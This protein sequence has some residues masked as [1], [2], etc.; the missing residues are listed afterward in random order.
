MSDRQ[1]AASPFLAPSAFQPR[2]QLS[3]NVRFKKNILPR[4]KG[5]EW[6]IDAMN[7]KDPKL[8]VLQF[9][10]CINKQDIE[11]LSNLM[12]DNHVFIDSSDDVHRGKESMIKGWIEFFN[13]YPDYRNH[14]P[15]IESRENLVLIIGYS[16]CSH[17]T[18]DGPAIW[19]AN[20]ENDLVAE[21]RVYL[22]TQENRAKLKL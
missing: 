22:D 1:K 12:A 6:S 3:S 4:A 15:K 21:W 10:E 2:R 14:F 20:I 17:N 9:N 11:G 8:T 19:T 16:T 13:L 7:K 18:L 5:I